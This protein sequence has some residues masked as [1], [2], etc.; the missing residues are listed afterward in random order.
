MLRESTLN[1][2]NMCFEKICKQDKVRAWL[3]KQIEQRNE[4]YFIIGLRTLA[5]PTASREDGAAD[6]RISG[7]KVR[8]VLWSP[9]GRMFNWFFGSFDIKDLCMEEARW[10]PGEH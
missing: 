4:V 10:L 5:G 7:V 3:Q 1:N 8:R 6:E 2:A 9:W